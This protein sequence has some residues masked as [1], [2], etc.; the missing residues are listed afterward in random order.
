MK[1]IQIIFGLAC[2]VAFCVGLYLAH[3][4]KKHYE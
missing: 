3:L 4:I 1:D 2:L